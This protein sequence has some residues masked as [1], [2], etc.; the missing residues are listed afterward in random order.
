MSC[1]QIWPAE[2][3]IPLRKP[4]KYLFPVRR[5]FLCPNGAQNWGL[6]P[7]QLINERRPGTS[8]RTALIQAV[9]TFPPFLLPKDLQRNKGKEEEEKSS[10]RKN[11]PFKAET[12]NDSDPGGK[13]AAAP[14]SP[15]GKR[16]GQSRQYCRRCRAERCAPSG[17]TCQTSR[18]PAPARRRLPASTWRTGRPA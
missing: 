17:C 4:Q 1:F 14:I 15:V 8:P 9:C 7:L 5:T 11:I 12:G 13:C 18:R 2:I 10:D 6:V 3:R 16:A